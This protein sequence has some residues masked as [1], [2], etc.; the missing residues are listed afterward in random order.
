MRRVGDA[1]TVPAEKEALKSIP[2]DAHVMTDAE[3]AKYGKRQ[4]DQRK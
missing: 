4:K 2:E 1:R 3:K